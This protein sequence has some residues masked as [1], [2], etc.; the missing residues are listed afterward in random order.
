MSL[1]I[2]PSP[3]PLREDA[4]HV[5]RVAGTRVTLDTIVAAFQ[6]GATPEEIAQ[7]YPSLP[8]ADVYAVVGYYL[9][10]KEQVDEYLRE[11][12]QVAAETRR[13]NE[14]KYPPQDVR[15]RLLAR[16]KRQD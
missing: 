3:V 8:L 12:Q 1:A 15:A 6:D 14:A 4:D 2:Q 7:Q 9:Q 11:R 5:V 16:E 10:H 13:Q